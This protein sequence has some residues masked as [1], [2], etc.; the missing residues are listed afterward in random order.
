MYRGYDIAD[1]A[2]QGDLLDAVHLLLWGGSLPTASER[3]KL[4]Q[5]LSDLALIPDTLVTMMGS[6]D[7][8]AHPMAVMMSLAGALAAIYPE[9]LDIKNAALRDEACLS[10]IAKAP[11]LA[12]L[13]HKRARNEPFVYPEPSLS[14]AANLL[15]MLHSRP[16][17][18]VEV[19]PILAEALEKIVILHMDHEQNC[20]TSAVRVAGSSQTHPFAALGAG[21]AALWGPSHGGANEAVLHMLEEIGSTPHI[22]R[23]IS[24][25]KDKNDPFRLMGFGHRVYK[26]YDPRAKIMKQVCDKVLTHLQLDD[27]LLAVAVELERI[28]TTDPYFKERGLYPNVDFYS[29]IVLRALGIPVSMYTALFAVS[30]T[31]GWMSQWREMVSE[32]P[33]MKI[34]R[35]R[36]R[37]QGRYPKKEMVPKHIRDPHSE[38]Q[39]RSRL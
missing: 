10:A 14:Y 27:P 12:A 1:V 25:A 5:Q 15:H 28:A 26:T 35:P 16:G 8:T 37:F 19:D 4:R 38:P 33:P 13:A 3:G 36:Q 31:V 32:V 7:R 22:P 2:S 9:Y 34:A 23:F 6:F 21:M 17:R 39:P 20:S 24:R 29:G 18:V 11:V 30:R